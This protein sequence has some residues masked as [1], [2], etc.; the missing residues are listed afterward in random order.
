M[1]SA[2][3]LQ[4]VE[5]ALKPDSLCDDYYKWGLTLH[6]GSVCVG[7]AEDKI[8]GPCVVSYADF[9]LVLFVCL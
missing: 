8:G 7:S 1:E 9:M 4:V 6:K 2:H 3:K 5:V